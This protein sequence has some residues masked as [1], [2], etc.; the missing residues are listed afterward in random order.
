MELEKEIARLRE[1]N[2]QLAAIIWCA[3]ESHG[4]EMMIQDRTTLA[5]GEMKEIIIEK[6]D[7]YVILTSYPLNE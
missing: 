1:A 3:V 5:K 7:G 2:E 6:K 4:G